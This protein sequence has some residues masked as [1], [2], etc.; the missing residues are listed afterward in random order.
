MNPLFQAILAE[1]QNIHRLLS[2]EVPP[3]QRV[4]YLD[5]FVYRYAQKSIEQA[6][7]QK[8]ARVV[9]GLMAA[10]VLLREGLLQE[11]GATKRGLDE[12]GEDVA[13]LSFAVIDGNVTKLHREYLESFYEE[14]FSNPS[15]PPL[16]DQRR[17]M[18]P[19]K[20]IRAFIAAREEYG[21]DPSTGVSLSRTISKA[22]SGYVHAAS[23]QIME[24]YGGDPPSFCYTIPKTSQLHS[25]AAEDTW[26]YVYRGT[27]AFGLAATA[28]RHEAAVR[29]VY[30]I[31]E[32][33]DPAMKRGRPGP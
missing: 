3:P 19:R 8:L 11:Q 2:A 17:G 23:P 31:F 15:N 9:S 24:M 26:N 27:C 21:A 13:F 18:V 6:I 28:L 12:I 30:G 20:K 1:L 25:S 4:P 29:R 22:Y 5:H 10:D 7:V 32:K 14:E 16:S 33:L